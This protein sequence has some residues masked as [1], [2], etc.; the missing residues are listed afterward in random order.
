MSTKTTR[1]M[2]QLAK[3]DK[4]KWGNGMT[5]FG[6]R[7]KTYKQVNGSGVCFISRSI[8]PYGRGHRVFLNSIAHDIFLFFFRA[9]QSPCWPPHSCSFWYLKKAKHLELASA[10]W[11]PFVRAGVFIILQTHHVIFEDGYNTYSCMNLQIFWNDH[12]KGSI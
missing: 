2:Q 9:R 4:D 8:H 10:L 3:S 6:D 12:L 11:W 5:R 7:K 1:W